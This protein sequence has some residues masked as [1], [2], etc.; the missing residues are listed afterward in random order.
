[1][2]EAR[3][4]RY[5]RLLRAHSPRRSKPPLAHDLFVRAQREKWRLVTTSSVVL[6]AHALLLNRA[7][8]GRETALAFLGSISADRYQV[9]RPTRSD[10]QKAL[11]IVRSHGDKA[12]SLCDAV[13]FAVMERLGIREAIAFDRDFRTYGRFAIL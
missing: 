11:A 10:E 9:V 8:P 4:R 12:Y 2:R 3:L 1:M 7:R 6:E 13:S 5:Q